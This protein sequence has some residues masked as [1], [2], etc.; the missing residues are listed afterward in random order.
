MSRRDN[1]IRAGK[2]FIDLTDLLKREIA[3][4]RVSNR[5]ITD[6]VAL[7]LEEEKLLPIMIRRAKKKKRRGLF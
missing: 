4:K 3:P 1:K 2:R 7:F 5:E 6:S